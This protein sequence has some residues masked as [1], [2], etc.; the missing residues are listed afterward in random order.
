MAETLQIWNMALGWVGTRTVAAQGEHT[1]EAIQCELFW[2]NARRQVLR[3]FPWNF[4]QRRAWLAEVPMP[5]GW[6][7]AYRHAYALPGDCLKSLQVL[8]GGRVKASFEIAYDHAQ[9][10]R[11]LLTDAEKAL[12][13]YTADVP[14]VHMGDDLFAHLLA[15]KLA[16]LIA[17]PLLRNNTSKVQELEQLYRAAIPSALTAD[18]SEGGRTDK[19][20]AWIEARS[21]GGL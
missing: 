9:A 7:T 17:V 2:D 19:T 5:E 15:R 10:C 16:A 18:A 21:G 4:A 6:E 11:V 14:H 8:S 3:D 1:Q 13:A 12:L 20:D